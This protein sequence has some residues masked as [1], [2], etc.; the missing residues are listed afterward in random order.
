VEFTETQA[1]ILTNAYLLSLAGNGQVVQD[2]CLPD[3]HRLC[4]AGWLDRHIIGDEVT[5]WWSKQAEGALQ[6]SELLDEQSPN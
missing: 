4:E 5:W 3:A 1:E 2:E 6:L